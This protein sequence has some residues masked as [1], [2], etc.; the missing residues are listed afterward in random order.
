VPPALRSLRGYPGHGAFISREGTG[1][2]F[3]APDRLETHPRGFARKPLFS[4]F[5]FAS[6]I[7]YGIT[8]GVE[9]LSVAQL[10]A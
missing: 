10:T 2:A 1:G 7:P 5:T 4:G 8:Y 9:R 6:Y 3:R